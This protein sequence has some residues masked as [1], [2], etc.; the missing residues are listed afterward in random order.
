M[1]TTHLGTLSTLNCVVGKSGLRA[2][3]MDGADIQE[4]PH[5]WAQRALAD[6]LLRC[7]LTLAQEYR[8]KADELL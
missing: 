2:L 6:V 3:D 7:K 1:S 5:A 4:T 8:R